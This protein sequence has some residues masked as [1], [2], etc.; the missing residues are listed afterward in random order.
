MS[1]IRGQGTQYMWS[2]AHWSF[3]RNDES[4]NRYVQFKSGIIR[5][6]AKN[7]SSQW[8]QSKC[9]TSTKHSMHTYT[10]SFGNRSLYIEIQCALGVVCIVNCQPTRVSTS[11]FS[12]NFASH[13]YLCINFKERT[14]C[15]FHIRSGM[16]VV[17]LRNAQFPYQYVLIRFMRFWSQNVVYSLPI[18]TNPQCSA[19][20]QLFSC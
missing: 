7:Y 17:A 4:N 9:C 13:Q 2:E 3:H 18:R 20:K 15:S 12:L 11:F 19:C 16:T 1:W 6:L 14:Q 5:H 8:K 10:E